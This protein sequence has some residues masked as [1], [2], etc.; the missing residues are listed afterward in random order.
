MALLTLSQILF[1]LFCLSE[2]RVFAA[3]ESSG[4][5]V[6]HELQAALGNV[7]TLPSQSQYLSLSTENWYVL[8]H[9][10]FASQTLILTGRKQPGRSR[11]VSFDHCMYHNFSKPLGSSPAVMSLL[12]F[13][14]EAICP[15]LWGRIST[16]ES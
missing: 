15:P 10:P 14:P 7:T 2:I 9:M 12:Q 3:P 11:R 5:R 13:A 6:C 8:S 16:M 1:G 4:Q